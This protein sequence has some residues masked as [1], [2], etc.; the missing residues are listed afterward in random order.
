MQRTLKLWRTFKEGMTNF[1]RNGWL[2]FATITILSLS[3]FIISFA[4][5]ITIGTRLIVNN[6][7]DRISVTVSFNPDIRQERILQMQ[8]NLKRFREI[9]SVEYVSREQALEDFLKSNGNDPVIRQ[10]IDEIGENPLLASLVI[11]AKKQSDYEKIAAVLGSSEYQTDINRINFEKNRKIFER[12]NAISEAARKFGLALGAAFGLIAILITFNTIRI[13]IYSHRQEFEIMRLVGASN[14]YVR[15]PYIFEGILYGICAGITATAL[16]ALGSYGLS[17]FTQGAFPQGDL[18][19]VF[20]AYFPMI[21]ALTLL[22]G[23]V[24]GVIS[25]FIAIHRYLKA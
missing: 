13:T 4:G 22:L 24:L 8:E 12:L 23:I 18:F 2:S 14:L 11:R 17:S 10:A 9:E 3:L 20:L 19:H 7:E 21:S 1:R 15:M 25:S 5:L 6:L 16:V